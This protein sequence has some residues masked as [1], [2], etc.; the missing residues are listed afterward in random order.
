MS[1]AQEKSDLKVQGVIE[2][3][4]D[5]NSSVTPADAQRKIVEESKKAGVTAFTFDANATTAEKRAQARA[6]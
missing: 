1:I 6:V 5:P 4:Q 3:A 2:A